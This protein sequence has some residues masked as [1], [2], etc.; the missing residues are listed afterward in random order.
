[1]YYIYRLE[2]WYFQTGSILPNEIKDVQT[3]SKEYSEKNVIMNTVSGSLQKLENNL[4]RLFLSF[5][6]MTKK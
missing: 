2:V 4:P 6:F 5:P 3:E 1:M